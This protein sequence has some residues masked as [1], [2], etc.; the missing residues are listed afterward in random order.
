MTARV[1]INILL[2]MP[3]D[4]EVFLCYKKEHIDEYGEKCSGYCFNIDDV[5]GNEIMFTDWRDKED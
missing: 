4:D 3:M 2:D 5:R 1:L